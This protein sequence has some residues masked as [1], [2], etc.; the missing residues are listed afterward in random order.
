MHLF[1]LEMCYT[2]TLILF[3]FYVTWMWNKKQNKHTLIFSEKKNNLI[4]EIQNLEKTLEKE[5]DLIE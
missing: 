3:N 5:K 2:N 1:E 4:D